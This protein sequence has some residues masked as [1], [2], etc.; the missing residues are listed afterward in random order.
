MTKIVL[1]G[2]NDIAKEH[3]EKTWSERKDQFGGRQKCK[4]VANG[5]LEFRK[6]FNVQCQVASFETLSLNNSTFNLQPSFQNGSVNVQERRMESPR[7]QKARKTPRLKRSKMR[8]R[9][10]KKLKKN[11]PLKQKRKKKKRKK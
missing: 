10:K 4:F 11:Q 3:S 8:S 2:F 7:P 6:L 5:I 1:Q 9:K